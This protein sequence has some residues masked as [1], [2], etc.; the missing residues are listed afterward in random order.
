VR[1]ADLSRYNPSG[2]AWAVVTGASAG[3]GRAYA[4]ELARLKFNVILIS[5]TKKSLDEVGDFIRIKYKVETLSVPVDFSGP[6]DSIYDTI[7]AAI[8][9]KEIGILVNNVG[10]NYPYPMNFLDVPEEID[11][12]I[13]KINVRD[14][15]KMTRLILPQMVGRRSG[16]IINLGSISSKFPTPMLATYSASKGYID[17]FTKA[18]AYEYS[19]SGVDFQVSTPYFVVSSMSKFRKTSLLVCSPQTIARGSL[20]NIGPNRAIQYSPYIIHAFALAL[21]SFLPAHLIAKNTLSTHKRI[22]SIALK[23]A[24]NAKKD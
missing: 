19:A 18:L 24:L 11:D 6:S 13:T 20:A 3:I 9:D 2:E 22:N 21:V 10:V 23:K 15:N 16:A 17:L 1:K 7:S 5:R 8:K 12:N 4:E 14:L